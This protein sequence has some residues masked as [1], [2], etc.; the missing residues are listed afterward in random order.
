[1]IAQVFRA[2]TSLEV[3]DLSDTDVTAEGCVHLRHC[4]RM[5]SLGLCNTDAGDAS[6]ASLAGMVRSTVPGT[7]A[8]LEEHLITAR[9]VFS[10]GGWPLCL[11]QGLLNA[12]LTDCC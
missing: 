5:L 12:V 9:A 10:C 3:L 2:L 6:A 11:W 1:M 7:A 4:R 8:A